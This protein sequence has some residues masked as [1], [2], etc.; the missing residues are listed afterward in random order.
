MNF[1]DKWLFEA[2]KARLSTD[3]FQLDSGANVDITIDNFNVE[4]QDKIKQEFKNFIERLNQIET[5]EP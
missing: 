5:Q 1:E 3:Y 2:P 4:N